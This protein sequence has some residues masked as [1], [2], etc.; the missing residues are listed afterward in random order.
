MKFSLGIAVFLCAGTAFAQGFPQKPVRLIVPSAPGGTQDIMARTFAQKVGEG[1]KQQVVVDNRT[2][3]GG[4]ISA[5]LTAKAPPNGYTLL[6]ISAQMAISAAYYKKLP[7]DAIKDFAPVS[8]LTGT[9]FIL[10]S[11]MKVPATSLQELLAVAR[12]NPGKLNYSSSGLG[13]SLHL[14]MELMKSLGKVDIVHV[15]Y[16]SDALAT[17]ALMADEVQVAFLPTLSAIRLMKGGK[18]RGI[19]IS[20]AKRNAAAPDIPTLKEAGL[21]D[22]EFGSWL[23]VFA[24]AGTPRDLVHS[25]SADFVRA[26]HAPDVAG[27]LLA[28]GNEIVG[29]NPE[30]F[31]AKYKADIDLYAKIIRDAKVPLADAE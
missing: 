24:P 25:I 23:A 7:Y 22:Y 31:A 28:A 14:A 27:K 21:P 10:T 11:N 17:P 3:A 6:F 8:Q 15:P 29:S 20:S 1:W 26:A 4:A 2:G 9:A 5:D 13:S 18:I 12:K 16:K 30:T 19:A